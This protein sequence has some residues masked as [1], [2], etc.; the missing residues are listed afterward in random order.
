MA[1]TLTH[2]ALFDEDWVYKGGVITDKGKTPTEDGANPKGFKEVEVKRFPQHYETWD[3]KSKSWKQDL[4][5]KKKVDREIKVLEASRKGELDIPLGRTQ[6]WFYLL[7][8]ELFPDTHISAKV[9]EDFFPLID[10]E[11]PPKSL[12]RPKN[13]RGQP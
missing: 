13:K 5:A 7:L 6:R 3:Q 2:W 4:R 10:Q 9:M 1:R 12:Q 8:K 11:E